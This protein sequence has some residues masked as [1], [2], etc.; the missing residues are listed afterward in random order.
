[1]YKLLAFDLDHTLSNPNEVIDPETIEFLHEA[2]ALGL[3][4]AI[5]SGRPAMYL[6]GL[7]RQIGL[8]NP[9]ITGENGAYTYYHISFPP[10]LYFTNEIQPDDKLKFDKL[11]LLVTE[12]FGRN[13]WIQPNF[14]NF[15]VFPMNPETRD[16]LLA[17]IKDYY[18][19]VINDSAYTFYIHPDDSF[20][21][22]PPGINKGA[23]LNV[24]LEH[25]GFTKDQVIA[26][27]NSANDLPMLQEAGTSIGINYDKADHNF[28][29]IQEAIS[30]IKE[31][32]SQDS[33]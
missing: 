16:E 8:K 3:K 15:A 6:G 7:G 11:R 31:L 12:K 33:K 27:G 10:T 9:I 28:N 23:A 17:F 24:I 14:T 26:V 18:D 21:I 5:M 2:E 1:M 19:N 22:V 25:E 13:A 32:L 20:E 30:F 4:I 29:S